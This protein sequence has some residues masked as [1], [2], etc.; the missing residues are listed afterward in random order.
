[1]LKSGF[2]LM[3]LFFVITISTAG[4][5]DYSPATDLGKLFTIGYVISGEGLF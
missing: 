1:M 5:E 3:L 2:G 4:F